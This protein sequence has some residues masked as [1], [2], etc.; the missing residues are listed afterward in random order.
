MLAV[1]VPSGVDGDTGAVRGF[2]LR[3]DETVTFVAAKPGHLLQ[4]GRDL[5]G[6]LHVADIGT[7]AAAFEAGSA[8][9][10][11]TFRNGPGLWS[12]AFPRLADESHKYT[13][14]HALVLSGPATRTGAARLS[15]RGALRVGAGLVTVASPERALAENAAHLTAIMLRVCDSADDLDDLITDER[16]NA[17][18][19]G[20]GLGVGEATRDLVAVAAA[21]GRGLVLDADALTSFSSR[22]PSSPPTSPPAKRA[23]SSRRMRASSENCSRAPTPSRRSASWSRR[24]APRCRLARWSC[25]KAPTR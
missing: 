20:P 23:R 11:P 4:P 1:D 9:G 24:A 15:A 10:A 8:V 6:S 3:A 16:I 25:S 17:I 14:G 19:A 18:L 13:R 22:R 21:A 2:A 12:A 5:C 7:G